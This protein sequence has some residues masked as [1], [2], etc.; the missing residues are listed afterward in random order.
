MGV[1]L[2]FARV[3]AFAGLITASYSVHA[4]S[5]LPQDVTTG[6][7]AAFDL[8]G[9]LD[10]SLSGDTI[11]NFTDFT[12]HTG[13]VLNVASD[14]P[15]FV[16]ANTVYLDGPVYSTAPE[17]LF[18]ANS[19][20]VGASGLISNPDGAIGLYAVDQ[21]LLSGPLDG[22]EVVLSTQSTGMPGSGGVLD[23]GTG[24]GVIIGLPPAP[25]PLPGAAWLFLSGLLALL[26]RGRRA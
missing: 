11:F 14:G 24:G 2:R 9:S 7:D 26:V 19:I 5:V 25:V 4:I 22:Y 8:T 1:L 17:I 3:M 16:Y 21:I 10:W 6:A 12:M 18:I 13:S 15:V 20:E 23:P